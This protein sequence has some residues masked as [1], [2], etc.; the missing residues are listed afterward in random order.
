MKLGKSILILEGNWEAHGADFLK[1]R[2][3]KVVNL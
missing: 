2:K 1:N 3:Y